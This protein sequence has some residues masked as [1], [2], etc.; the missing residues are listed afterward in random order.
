MRRVH[1]AMT[2]VEGA[3]A[4]GLAVEGAEAG[5]APVVVA[6]EVAVV[7]SGEIFD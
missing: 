4:A 6:A 7:A 1:R 2:L 3:E 5:A